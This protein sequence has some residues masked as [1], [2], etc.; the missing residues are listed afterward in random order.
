MESS[1]TELLFR[2]MFAQYLWNNIELVG[3][4]SSKDSR[5]DILECRQIN[6][7]NERSVISTLG[8]AKSGFLGTKHRL[9]DHLE[10]FKGLEREVQFTQIGESAGFLRRVSVGMHYRTIQDVDDG[11]GDRTRACRKYMLPRDDSNSVINL[12]IKG[13]TEIGPVLQVKTICH[14][15]IYP[16]RD[17]EP[18]HIWTRFQI[19]GCDIPR[20]EPWNLEEERRTVND[21]LYCG[22]V[23]H[24]AFRT[25]HSANQLSIYGAVSSWC[26]ELAEQMLGQ[27]S[28]E[29]DKSMSKENDPLTKQLDPQEKL[30]RVLLLG[31][32]QA[33]QK[34][35]PMPVWRKRVLLNGTTSPLSLPG[36]PTHR[37]DVSAYGEIRPDHSHRENMSNRRTHLSR[38]TNLPLGGR[39]KSILGNIMNSFH[40]RSWRA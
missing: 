32:N 35:P 26:Q 40:P 37:L 11:F 34:H 5:S 27:T 14:L 7:K 18:L 25:I 16:N 2:T 31:R 22:I 10:Q 19:L 24:W 36:V 8:S 15:D 20:P 17:S 9:R 3:R 4:P 30:F 13:H 33:R 23:K 39:C 12:W 21:S 28:M 29:V 1:N 38:E 6:F